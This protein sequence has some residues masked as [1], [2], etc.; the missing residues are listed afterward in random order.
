[1]ADG[2]WRQTWVRP[3]S[4]QSH[5]PRLEPPAPSNP[6]HPTPQDKKKSSAV[7]KPAAEAPKAPATNKKG[8]ALAIH[9][10][11][12]SIKKNNEPASP[13]AIPTPAPSTPVLTPGAPTPAPAPVGPAAV[14]RAVKTALNVI[15]NAVP[16]KKKAPVK[17]TKAEA[18]AV[19]ALLALAAGPAKKA[20]AKGNKKSVS[21]A[22]APTTSALDAL[23]AAV[24]A[25]SAAPSTS[26]TSSAAPAPATAAAA[27][28]VVAASKKRK[29]AGGE[30][31]SEEEADAAV[32]AMKFARV[33]GTIKAQEEAEAIEALLA[34]AA[35]A[36]R[37]APQATVSPAPCA[38]P[39]FHGAAAVPPPSQLA[40]CVVPLFVG[41]VAAK[42]AV[43]AME[44]DAA[45]SPFLPG[46]VAA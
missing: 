16:M 25:A 1:M 15:K 31:E 6:T 38:L 19:G 8:F 43:V 24:E 35:G 18:P 45:A 7:R 40:P 30:E 10:L 23:E 36:P 27:A 46:P 12:A 32:P 13:A 39:L 21:F 29:R 17:P 33:A 22:P 3:L 4:R 37:P 5:S 26:S 9:T 20:A 34:L 28:A 41:G 42:E 2:G 14:I 44:V 11:A